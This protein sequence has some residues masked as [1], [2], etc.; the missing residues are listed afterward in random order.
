MLLGEPT[1]Q[2][3]RQILDGV[4]DGSLAEDTLGDEMQMSPATVCKET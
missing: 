4:P 2:Y 1:V 3:D